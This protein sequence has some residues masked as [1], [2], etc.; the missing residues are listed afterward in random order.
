VILIKY[1]A[2][3][4]ELNGLGKTVFET[5]K[6]VGLNL[7]ECVSFYHLLEREESVDDLEN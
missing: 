5:A 3:F 4:E 2:N 6:D 1:K 7:S